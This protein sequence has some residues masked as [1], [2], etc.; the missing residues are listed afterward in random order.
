MPQEPPKK[1]RSGCRIFLIIIG[2]VVICCVGTM[3]I[4][5][6]AVNNMEFDYS[7]S[8]FEFLEQFQDGGIPFLDQFLG[9]PTQDEF[10]DDFFGTQVNLT[11]RNDF[12]IPA[13]F[14]YIS[15]SDSDE[16]GDDWLGGEEI[17]DPGATRTFQF[18]PDQSVDVSVLDCDGNLIYEEY[19][20]TL[21]GE[22]M[23][24]TLESTP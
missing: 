19:Q 23:F 5:W 7:T 1:G 8:G 15:P 16:W 9:E 6:Y 3:A 22:E 12:A 11:L 13:C 14:V 4:G 24:I 18:T 10:F 17:I 2:V 21:T 20:I